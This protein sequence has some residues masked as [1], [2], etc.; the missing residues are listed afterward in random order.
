MWTDHLAAAG[1]A[2]EYYIR[3][4]DLAGNKSVPSNIVYA[5]LPLEVEIPS[6]VKKLIARPSFMKAP[7]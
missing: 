4:Y 6:E 2:Y 1:I 3:A 7:R 5:E